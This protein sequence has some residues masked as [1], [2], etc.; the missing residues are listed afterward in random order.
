MVLIYLCEVLVRFDRIL[1]KNS[2]EL[3]AHI[4]KTNSKSSHMNSSQYSNEIENLHGARG[5][6]SQRSTL[7]INC[8]GIMR[9]V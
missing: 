3:K 5:W 4:S 1:N 7:K 9:T 6:G 2:V 8:L